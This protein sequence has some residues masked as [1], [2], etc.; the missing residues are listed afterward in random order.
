MALYES[1]IENAY[2]AEESNIVVDEYDDHIESQRH[3]APH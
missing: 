3:Q 1:D 2:I